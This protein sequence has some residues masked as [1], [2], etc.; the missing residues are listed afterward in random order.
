MRLTTSPSSRAECHEMWEPKPPETLWATPGLL[1]DCFT[2]SRLKVFEN[3]V[4]RKMFGPKEEEV[5]RHWR[6]VHN[7]QLHDLYSLPTIIWVI[8]SRR[9][10]W[11]GHVGEK[12]NAYT[13]HS[14]I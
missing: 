12:K 3:R 2:F 5:T 14:R 13:L 11:V 4:R 6:E 7:E 9:M 10:S 8:R 1:R